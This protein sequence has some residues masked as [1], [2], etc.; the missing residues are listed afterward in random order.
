MKRHRNQGNSKEKE[1][2]GG[3]VIAPEGEFMSILEGSMAAGRQVWS[4]SG[5]NSNEAEGGIEG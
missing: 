5:D 1:Y 4:S 3:L 2:R